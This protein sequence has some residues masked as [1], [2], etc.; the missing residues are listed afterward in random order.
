MAPDGK[1]AVSS[2]ESGYLTVW[3]TRT[4]TEQLTI[5]IEPWQAALDVDPKFLPRSLLSFSPD[6]AHLAIALLPLIPPVRSG[7]LRLGRESV[8]SEDIQTQLWPSIFP[9]WITPGVG[10]LGQDYTFVGFTRYRV[11]APGRPHHQLCTVRIGHHICDR[12]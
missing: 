1:H 8:S 11:A 4:W 2:T 5:E 9:R 3:D 7:M 10:I 12:F 6:S